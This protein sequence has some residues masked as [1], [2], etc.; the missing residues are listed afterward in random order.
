MAVDGLVAIVAHRIQPPLQDVAVND[1]GP[2]NRSVAPALVQ[3]SDVNEHRPLGGR[4]QSFGWLQTDQFLPGR[5]QEFVNPDNLP[6]SA[7]MVDG[8]IRCLGSGHRAND[9]ATMGHPHSRPGG[10]RHT[11][12]LA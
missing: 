7:Q 1:E 5:V 4:E 3:R 6:T 12:I 8:L 9:R 2:G 11:S 10:A